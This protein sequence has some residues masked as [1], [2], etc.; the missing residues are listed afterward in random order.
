MGR[1]GGRAGGRERS[2]RTKERRREG[3]K[4]RTKEEEEEEEASDRQ[5]G[6]R[7]RFCETENEKGRAGAERKGWRSS[8]AR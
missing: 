6:C 8:S 7:P 1:A 3:R 4:K 5:T 2:A